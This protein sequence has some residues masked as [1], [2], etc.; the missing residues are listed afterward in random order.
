MNKQA[1]EKLALNIR[2]LSASGVE[3]ANSGHPGMPMG[4]ADMASVLWGEF[5]RFDPADTNWA[6]RDRFV[7][8]AGHG[9]ML[10]YSLLHL[11]S[12]DLPM[13]ELENFRQFGSLTPGHPEYG[14]TPGVEVTTGPLGQGFANGVGMA[15]SQ[16]LY[17][18]RYNQELFSANVY[19]IVSDGD[20]MEGVASEAASLAGH[21]KL[22]NLIYM[23]DD[24]DISIGGHTDICFTESVTER[25]KAY[26]WEVQ[27]VDGHNL[28]EIHQ[29]LQTAKDNKGKPQL[30]SCRT[31]IGKGSPNKENTSGVHGAPLGS[32]ELELAKQN[33]GWDQS[34]NF[35]VLPEVKDFCAAVVKN[36]Q[37]EH[38]QWQEKF[39][40]WKSANSDLA[41][42]YE[43][44]ISKEIPAGL[45][46]ELF[47]TLEDNDGVA[48]RKIS[49]QAVQVLSKYLPGFIGGSAD[50]EP[51]NMTLVTDSGDITADNFKEKN[52]RFGVREHA[53]GS[54]ANGLV[55]AGGWIP[56]TGTF[57][58]FSDYMRPPMRLAALSHLQ[59]MFIFTHDSYFVGEDGPTHQPIEHLSALRLIPNLDVYRPADGMEA[60]ACYMMAVT[61][62]DKPST[63]MFTRQGVPKLPRPAGFKRADLYKGA[64]R[65]YGTADA[66]LVFVATGSEVSVALDS[67]KELEK[68]GKT[69]SVISIPCLEV[70][71]EQDQAYQDDLI[72]DAAQKVVIEAGT[73]WGWGNI[74]GKKAI[75]ITKETYGASAPGKVLA[76]E[77]G[78]TAD[79]VVSRVRSAC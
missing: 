38:A 39:N 17:A 9:S 47:S 26:G 50:L 69:V 1:L 37:Q 55:Y 27:E 30:I 53:M 43:M 14:L 16:K 72:P 51:S 6:G 52:L 78:F 13:K 31:K 2:V 19:G 56:Y 24:N 28:E 25:F 68:S 75:F 57:L 54:I 21:W 70:F 7:L 5:L 73:S 20:L 76:E 65:L 4:T 10:L 67:A 77:F 61:R 35:V 71:L 18:D 33:M 11:F 59:S 64:Y 3:A 36:N 44:Q 12:F 58:V 74:V 60:A 79:Q 29:A 41:A 23:Y 48:T 63:L 45:E 32:E 49:G 22:D 46:D 34:E 66:E 15:L 62:Q 8:S 42:R 40:N